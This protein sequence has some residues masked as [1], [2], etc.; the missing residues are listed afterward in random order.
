MGRHKE[1][2]SA[3]DSIEQLKVCHDHLLHA[4]TL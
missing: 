3:E 2:V 1:D 4:E